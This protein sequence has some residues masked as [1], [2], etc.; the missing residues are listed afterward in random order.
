MNNRYEGIVGE[1]TAVEYLQAKGYKILERNYANKVGEI[2]IIAQDHDYIVFVEVKRRLDDRYG[3]ALEAVT[4]AKIAKI[5][6]CAEW[7]LTA[8]R[9]YNADVRFDIVTVGS[10]GVEHLVNAFTRQDAGRRNHW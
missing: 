10:S 7:Y 1:E 5:V 2:D 8:H 9:Q 4:P 6:R 3:R